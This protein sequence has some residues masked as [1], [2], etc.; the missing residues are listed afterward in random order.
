MTR[1]L[2]ASQSPRRRELLGLCGHPFEV[3]AAHVD[4]E[5]ISDPDPVQ[6]C[7]QTAQLKGE[8]VL[9]HLCIP[10]QE[11]TIVIAADTIVTLDGQVLGKPIDSFDA[12]KMLTALRGR[13]HQ[14][15]T[16]VTIIDTGTGQE[17]LDS[18]SAKVKMRDYTDQEMF[19]YIV[20]GDPLDKAGAYAIQHSIFKPVENL[21]GCF[22]G[23][24]GLS[25]C[26]LLH[27]F[28]L[29]KIPFQADLANLAIAHQGFRCSL[30]DNIAQK[31]GK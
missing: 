22:L 24:M 1:F 28:D 9:R 25:I 26:H 16:G 31:H 8:A 13:A 12:K 18:H 30:Y 19:T 10:L 20:S 2:L 17:V 15:H 5:S 21:I 29:F 23:V 4:E 27:L 11:R 7:I 6:N 3:V 14:V